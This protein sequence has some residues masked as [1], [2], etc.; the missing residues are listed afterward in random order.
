MDHLSDQDL[1]LIDKYLAGS[2]SK[3]EDTLFQKK[4]IEPDFK[5]ELDQVQLLK[6]GIHSF[7]LRQKKSLLQEE[8]KLMAK[9]KIKE[10]KAPSKLFSIQGLLK[11]AAALIGLSLLTWWGLKQLDQGQQGEVLFAQY[12]TPQKN[13]IAPLEKGIGDLSELQLALSDYENG[14]YLKA[15][16]SLEG[17]VEKENKDD[18]RFYLANALLATDQTNRAI[19]VLNKMLQGNTSRFLN[20]AKW[21][22]AL[23]Y[24]RKEQ[25]TDARPLLKDLL[26]HPF[27]KSNAAAILEKLNK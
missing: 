8:E 21:L 5:A 13:T 19:I 15:I 6:I 1:E 12:F 7:E 16:E 26:T 22:L 18:H 11:I 2:L 4:I 24:L 14:D 25:A 9:P 17:L 20:D 23:S 10:A 3:E 27:Y